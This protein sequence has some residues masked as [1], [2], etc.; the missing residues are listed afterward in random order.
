M[1]S[2]SCDYSLGGIMRRGRYYLG[3]V[4]KLGRLDKNLLINA[5]FRPAIITAKDYRW[6]ITDVSEDVIDGTYYVF[7]KLSKY[8]LEGHVT[9][10]DSDAKSLVDSPTP[11]LLLATSPFVYLPDYSGIAYLHVW[12]GIQQDIFRKR[13]KQIIELTYDN[14]FVDCQIEP[15]TDYRTFVKRISRI[16]SFR[17]ISAKIHPPNPLFGRLWEKLEKYVKKRNAQEINIKEI[18]EDGAG[19]QTNLVPLIDSILKNPNYIPEVAPDIAD[20]AILMAADGYGT[21]KITGEEDGS[22][23]TIKTGD[24]QK[25]FLFSKEPAPKELATSASILLEKI[26]KERDMKHDD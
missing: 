23:V 13:F 16:T 6:T 26:N 9:M 5:I 20:A 7:G 10:V 19:I 14:F 11:N 25:S 18:K 1:G 12:D 4:L 21:G 3:R 24:N 17:E 2:K 15:I 8:T 22:I